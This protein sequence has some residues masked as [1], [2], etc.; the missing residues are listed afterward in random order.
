MPALYLS[1]ST[2]R[3]QA[4]SALEAGLPLGRTT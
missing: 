2:R 1:N 4:G 3:L